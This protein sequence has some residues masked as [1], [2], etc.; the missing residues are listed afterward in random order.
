MCG[1]GYEIAVA[2]CS[3]H[4]LGC[5]STVSTVEVGFCALRLTGATRRATR[6]D[7]AG[8]G[9]VW[10]AVPVPCLDAVYFRTLQPARSVRA[11][12]PPRLPPRPVAARGRRRNATRPLRGTRDGG[13]GPLHAHTAHDTGS[14][15]HRTAELSGPAGAQSCSRLWRSRVLKSDERAR[16]ARAASC[17]SYFS[18][19]Q[20]FLAGII[21]INRA[22]RELGSGGRAAPPEGRMEGRPPAARRTARRGTDATRRAAD[23]RYIARRIYMYDIVCST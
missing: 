5:W 2:G 10:D 6:A 17:G 11:H 19:V 4:S 13:R 18:D 8:R 7:R 3:Y 23:D 15:G 16:L 9:T 20:G 21:K 12:R 14:Q 22:G 1:D